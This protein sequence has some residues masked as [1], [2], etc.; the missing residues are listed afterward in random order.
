MPMC[1]QKRERERKGL[2]GGVG[3]REKLSERF[4]VFNEFL[5]MSIANYWLLGFISNLD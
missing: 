5:T 2:G 1:A 4:H 3:E